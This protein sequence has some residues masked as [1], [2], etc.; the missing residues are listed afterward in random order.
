MREASKRIATV[1]PVF[2][3]PMP[4]AKLLALL[5]A[6]VTTL[7]AAAPAAAVEKMF[8]RDARLS[9]TQQFEIFKDLR[10]EVVQ[11]VISWASTAPTRPSDPRNPTDPAYRWPE[12]MDET[13]AAARANGMRTA[14]L[15]QHTPDWANGG[16]GTS[17]TP[18]RAGD[19]AAFLQATAKRYPRNRIWMIWGEP[20]LPPRFAPITPQT[21]FDV[22]R[23]PASV[24][25]GPKAYAK[26]VDA[27]YG[28][29]KRRSSNHRIVGGMS[30]VNCAVRPHTWVK[31]MRLPNGR[32]PRMDFYGHNP[33]TARRPNL[34]K[35]QSIQ[36]QVDFS[37]LGRFKKTVTR[38]LAKPRGK[39]S[40]P[41][42]LSEWA[43]PTG[44]DDAE[45]NYYTTLPLQ[46]SWI[47]SGFQVAKKLGAYGLGW[48]H[49][50]DSESKAAPCSPCGI[51]LRTGLLFSDGSKK[52]GYSA[53]RSAR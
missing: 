29:L 35:P 11:D 17:H 28:T 50:T 32:P 20:C 46:A 21:R 49:L 22:P 30:T 44:A 5:V 6:A 12:V 18:N 40:L 43:I 31:Y 14:I 53:F 3:R 36:E 15:V 8:W 7:V 19:F 16:R 27:A 24:Q 9:H 48:I 2:R 38:Y 45:F 39:R 33:F 52:P 25:R 42:F 26:L 41:F 34:Q 4:F 13:V 10:V 51:T 1:S 37:D 47:R 23:Q